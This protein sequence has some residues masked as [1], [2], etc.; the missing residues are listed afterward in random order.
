LNYYPIY[1]NLKNKQCVLIGGGTVGYRKALKLIEA[2][3]D[4]TIISPALCSELMSLA[5]DNKFTHIN[6]RYQSG[7]LDNAFIAITATNDESLNAII[8]KEAICPIN[9][10][11]MPE[12]CTFILPSII[13]KGD[14]NIAV[15]TSGV[16]PALARTLRLQIEDYIEK[17]YSNRLEKYLSYLKSFRDKV[18]SL[19]L[20]TEKREAVLKFAG[21][22]DAITLLNKHGLSAIKDQLERQLEIFVEHGEK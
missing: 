21:S 17:I 2:G 10:V 19:N 15:S 1:L 20:I 16:S 6:R 14:L 22:I 9:A 13:Q 12:Y 8:S 3:A 4:L 7:D 18:F 11:D 5:C